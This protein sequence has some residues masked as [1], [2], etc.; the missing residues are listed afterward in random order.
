MLAT[1]YRSELLLAKCS[2]CN[3]SSLRISAWSA[4]LVFNTLC[5]TTLGILSHW[6]GGCGLKSALASSFLQN[7]FVQPFSFYTQSWA[8]PCVHS[9]HAGL[10]NSGACSLSL[11]ELGELHHHIV[12][13]TDRAIYQKHPVVSLC[14]EIKSAHLQKLWSVTPCII[15]WISWVEPS[16]SPAPL[17]LLPLQGFIGQSQLGSPEFGTCT[18]GRAGVWGNWL[19]RDD[20][21]QRRNGFTAEQKWMIYSCLGGTN[22]ITLEQYNSSFYAGRNVW[23]NSTCRDQKFPFTYGGKTLARDLWHLC[24]FAILV[25]SCLRWGQLRAVKFNLWVCEMP[26]APY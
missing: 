21:L 24:V 18:W 1:W 4:L 5:V 19:V 23:K 15:P 2:D 12:P 14:V 25:S 11:T 22:W 10:A 26:Q 3:P 16:P 17:S 20:L 13:S 8:E 9:P 6:E 7:A